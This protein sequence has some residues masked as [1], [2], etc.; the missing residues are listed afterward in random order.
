MTL[1]IDKNAPVLISAENGLMTL[2]LNRPKAINSLNLEMIQSMQKAMDE[3]ARSSEVRLVLIRGEGEKG[4]CAGADVK[5][6]SQAVAEGRKDEAMRFFI[7]E[8]ALDLSIH[9]FP[10]P[11]VVLAHGITMGGGLGLAAGADL[12]LVTET[13]RMAMPETRIGFFPDVGATG[14]LFQKCPEGYAE[15]LTLTGYEVEGS[16]C[17]RLGLAHDIM[18]GSRITEAR[19]ILQNLSLE[20]GIEKSRSVRKIHQALSSMLKGKDFPDVRDEDLWVRE[21]FS[22]RESVS[23]IILS[24]SRSKTMPDRCEAALKQFSDRSPTAAVLTLSLLRQ[25][26]NQSLEQVFRLETSATRFIISHP[27]YR[28]GVRARLVDKDNQPEWQPDRLD[29]VTLPELDPGL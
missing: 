6:A 15:Y 22:G 13:T 28:E 7:E 1:T 4:F 21:N 25:N 9:R 5:A 19:E 26:Q 23:E 11:V 8:Y 20:P 10:K 18:D 2:T 24:L 14:W 16:E 12:V 27:D 3:A 17:V 29:Q